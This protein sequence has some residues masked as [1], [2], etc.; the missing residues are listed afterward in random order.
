MLAT[1]GQSADYCYLDNVLVVGE[2]G[3]AV[4][5]IYMDD[6]YMIETQDVV[7]D[8][9]SSL[10]NTQHTLELRNE[11][12]GIFCN[13]N[14]VSP[15]V[16]YTSFNTICDMPNNVQ[17]NA[18]ARLYVTADSTQNTTHIFNVTTA[19]QDSTKL[20][21]DK[22]YFSPQ[23]LQG[24][25]TKIYALL[26]LGTNITVDE[27]EITITFPDNSK[28]TLS[29]FETTNPGE[30]ESHITDTY[31]VGITYFNIRVESGIYFDTYNN[32][33]IVAAYNLDFVEVVN[34][35]AV[36]QMVNESKMDI[37]GTEYAINDSGT[38]FLQLLD[39]EKLPIN[40]AL[41]YVDIYYPNKAIFVDDGFMMYLTDSDGL[42]Y[43]DLLIPN[44]TGV[45]ML[46][47][48]CEFI[49]NMT[50]N[51]PT[52]DAYVL[53]Y[54]PTFNYGSSIYLVAGKYLFSIYDFNYSS[55]IS[56]NITDLGSIDTS[57]VN[58]TSTLFLYH[59]LG[60]IGNVTLDIQR[61]TE[62]WDESNVT[63]ANGPNVD[64]YVYD[65]K[66]FSSP[67]WQGWDISELVEQWHNGTY[68]NYGIYVN[69]SLGNTGRGIFYSKEY[70]T[71][72]YAPRILTIYEKPTQHITEIRG[73]GELHVTD[74]Y[75]NI[76]QHPNRT[77]TYHPPVNVSLNYTAISEGVW[78]NNVTI[79]NGL[80]DQFSFEIW[81]TNHTIH[82]GL[83]GQFV[84][85]VWD[86]VARYTHG[87]IN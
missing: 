83:L 69:S 18:E 71:G 38:V 86:Y 54:Y 63:P 74:L 28:R 67:G 53:D 55:Y 42:Y 43:Y 20:N 24:G 15:S 70:N 32:N 49:W 39:E 56:F 9:T 33:Y 48:Y 21:I 13:N 30:Y 45:Y 73:S 77:L 81:G 82:P 4:L 58:I 31:Q 75:N 41:C 17:I 85:N 3:S 22:V 26:N 72:V 1:S 25:S 44:E 36:C 47:A 87:I 29:M 23:V 76:W 66:T 64:S 5:E 6:A 62:P 12:D 34:S 68:T 14:I 2:T 8:M 57:E 27:I 52:D 37:F 19:Q 60:I 46:S 80:L 65:T 78:Q 16:P 84:L 79:D 59:R 40:D 11:T 10:T 51:I 61:I 50:Y 7:I 35:V